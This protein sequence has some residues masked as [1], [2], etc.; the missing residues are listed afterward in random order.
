MTRRCRKR[1]QRTRKTAGKE[2]PSSPKRPAPEERQSPPRRLSRLLP[3]LLVLAAVG[4]AIFVV[5]P[6]PSLP[7]IPRIE[8]L[9]DIDPVVATAIREALDAIEDKPGDGTGYG[10]LGRLYHGGEHY[11]LAVE[12]YEIAHRLDPERAD[13]AYYLGRLEADRGKLEDAVG[14]LGEALRLRPG[15]LP[16]QLQRGDVFQRLGELDK[17]EQAYGEVMRQA[18]DKA[19]GFIGLGKVRRRQNR[20]EDAAR[21][22]EKALAF[23]PQDREVSYLLGSTY[24][25]LGRDAEAERLLQSFAADQGV[26]SWA[27]DD[28]LMDRVYQE[29]V[30]LQGLLRRANHLLSNG[31]LEE[32][33]A[34]YEQVLNRRPDEYAAIINLGNLYGRKGQVDRALT[35]L[36]RAVGLRP[37]DPHPRYGVAMAY[38]SKGRFSEALAQL[39]EVLRLEPGNAQAR[40]LAQRLRP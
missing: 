5:R 8:N 10:R 6:T 32:A 34:L 24:R 16:A 7:E 30:G 11:D 40:A 28:P 9:E 36:E 25:L 2:P 19:S 29:A 15:Y 39:D 13:W 17:A 20:F 26:S 27:L 37:E 33:E 38:A 14:H 35:M 21:E 12:C 18:P 3:A 4:L 31:R 1:S 22:L 23:A